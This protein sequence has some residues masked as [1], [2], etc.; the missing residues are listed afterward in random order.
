RLGIDPRPPNRIVALGALGS[1]LAHA[2]NY[3]LRKPLGLL[4]GQ[5]G[6][7]R[8]QDPPNHLV[9]GTEVR[10]GVAVE[11]HPLRSQ[12]LEVMDRRHH[13][14]AAKATRPS[15]DELT[16]KYLTRGGT[17]NVVARSC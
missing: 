17:F 12:P 13:T 10:L 16:P 14:L 1:G 9:I 3:T 8:Q 15:E 4:L 7:Y 6:E 11:R 5:G 2:H